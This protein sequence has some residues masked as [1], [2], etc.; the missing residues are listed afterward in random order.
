[1]VEIILFRVILQSSSCLTAC[2]GCSA[3]TGYANFWVIFLEGFRFVYFFPRDFSLLCFCF[4]QQLGKLGVLPMK[5]R[6]GLL[7]RPETSH[8]VLQGSTKR[9]KDS[10][11][12]WFHSSTECFHAQKVQRFCTI[13]WF[14]FLKVFCMIP[15]LKG[16]RFHKVP[17]FGSPGCQI[18]V[19]CN[20]FRQWFHRP[21]PHKGLR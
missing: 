19:P 18:K 16:S 2:L 4:T 14:R 1:M 12:E 20:A 13:Y 3:W 8:Q 15:H 9:F 11:T 17:H 7:R 6:G 5:L 21:T 10:S